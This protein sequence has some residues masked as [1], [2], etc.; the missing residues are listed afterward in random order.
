MPASPAMPFWQRS[1]VGYAAAITLFLTAGVITY[2]NVFP[3]G[4]A[5]HPT[6]LSEPVL[7]ALVVT[8]D[9]C[10]GS[11]RHHQFADIPPTDFARVAQALEKQLGQRVA[12]ASIGDGWTCRGAAIC[13]VGTCSAAHLVFVRTGDGSSRAT[14]S[15]FSMPPS[16]CRSRCGDVEYEQAGHPI[17][18]FARADGVFCLVGSS[19][20]GSLKPDDVRALRDHVRQHLAA[21]PA[22]P[23]STTPRLA[24]AD[25]PEE[26]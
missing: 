11:D 10:A 14:V 8:H 19:T 2:R 22:R 26:P 3:P 13:T 18:G 15:L 20:D 21:L 5:P 7:N 25:L 17:A 12:A 1:W 23:A 9:A 16:E 24:S 4:S 6:A